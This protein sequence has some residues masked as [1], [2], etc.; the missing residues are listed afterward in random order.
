MLYRHPAKG[1]VS[2]STYKISKSHNVVME[3]VIGL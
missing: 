2:D 1:P 3:Y